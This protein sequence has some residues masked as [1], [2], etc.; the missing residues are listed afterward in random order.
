[1]A[2]EQRRSTRSREPRSGAVDQQVAKKYK[3]ILST[4]L[5]IRTHFL[6]DQRLDR[7]DRYTNVRGSRIALTQC[8]I[9]GGCRG[10]GMLT[11]QISR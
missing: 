4:Y 10:G 7:D 2:N 1:M 9:Q 5:Y 6:E 11:I 3:Y 8:A